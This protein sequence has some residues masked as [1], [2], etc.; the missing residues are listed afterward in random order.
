MKSYKAGLRRFQQFCLH[1]SLPCFPLTQ[2]TLCRF[3]ALLN[4]KGLSFSTI[5]LYLSAL[6]FYQIRYRGPDPSFTDWPQL[7][8]SLRTIHRLQPT[9]V[10][11]A[12]L[13]VTPDVLHQLYTVW[14]IQPVS[15]TNCMLWAACCLGFYAF[16][17]SG[18]FTCPSRS[19]YVPSMLSPTDITVDTHSN[20]SFITVTLRASKTDIWGKGHTLYVGATGSYICPVAAVLSY[21]AIRPSSPS[22]L[23]IH[24][25]GRP[26]SRTTLVSEVRLALQSTGWDISRFNGHSFRIGAATTAASRGLSDSLIQILGRWKSSAFL[27]YLKS[28]KE[29]LIAVARRLSN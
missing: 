25:E 6:R 10:R 8:Y 22:P 2:H 4:H 20:P 19:T 1:Y 14:S 24:E 9:H 12:C 5:R 27:G 29:Q 26:L 16:L 15:Y 28:P 23:F 7:H 18:E 21:L 11:P 13:P 17:R 3:V